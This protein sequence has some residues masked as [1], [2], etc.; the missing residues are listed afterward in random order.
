MILIY[1]RHFQGLQGPSI[2]H[3][4]TNLR[5]YVRAHKSSSREVILHSDTNFLDHP[6]TYPDPN[7]DHQPNVFLDNLPGKTSY[8]KSSLTKNVRNHPNQ[9]SNFLF[10]SLKSKKRPRYDPLANFLDYLQTDPS[11]FI[12]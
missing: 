2:N 4:G 1:F 9:C 8:T 3:F 7:Q 5:T 12:G 11:L 6:Q 10:I